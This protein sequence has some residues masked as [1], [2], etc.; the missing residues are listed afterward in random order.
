MFV[1]YSSPD[2][3]V[4]LKATNHIGF[5]GSTLG[6]S[7]DVGSY[8]GVTAQVDI[9]GTAYSGS[10]PNVKYVDSTHCDFGTGTKLLTQVPFESCTLRIRTQ[11]N[12]GSLTSLRISSAKL[13][14]HNGAVHS[15]APVNMN[16]Y[17]FEKGNSTWTLMSGATGLSLTPP[18]SSGSY[19]HDYYVCL[20]MTPTARV[21]GSVSLSLYLESY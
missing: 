14:A 4:V 8:Q 3:S 5:F 10:F 1:Q 15:A 21:K 12:S 20:S 11:D 7:I 16:V 2:E 6:Q 13:L 19:V 17:G 18:I 9:V